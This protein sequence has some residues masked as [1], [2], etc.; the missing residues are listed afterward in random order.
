MDEG[1]WDDYDRALNGDKAKKEVIRQINDTLKADRDVVN[2]PAHY[3]HGPIETI[4]YM[5]S[6]YGMENVK[7]F[8]I[9]NAQKYFSRALLKNGDEDIK[10]GI[11]YGRF[12]I[13]DDPRKDRS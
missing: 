2:N 10:K 1:W 5:V 12:A 3:K 11:W 8:C 7:I 9:L 6:Q 13:G 4:D